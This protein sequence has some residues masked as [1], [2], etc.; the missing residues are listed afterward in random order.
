MMRFIGA[1]NEESDRRAKVA[2][3]DRYLDEL[4]VE[5][6]PASSDDEAAAREWADRALGAF[7]EQ[8]R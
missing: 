2:A 7:D 5:L 1:L 3:L 6:G 4:E 8:S